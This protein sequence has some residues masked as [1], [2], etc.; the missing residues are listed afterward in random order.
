MEASPVS[1]NLTLRGTAMGSGIHTMIT[2]LEPSPSW[3]RL[4]S[5]VVAVASPDPLLRRRIAS[6][7]HRLGYEVYLATTGPELFDLIFDEDH[8]I[9]KIRPNIVI[10]EQ[11]LPGITG[12]E[13]FEVVKEK[14]W[15]LPYFLIAPLP[16]PRTVWEAQRLRVT[17]IWDRCSKMAKMAKE[18]FELLPPI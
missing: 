3:Y 2:K 10:C 15:A 11:R 1:G 17:A 6:P 7:L 9:A 4:P 13:I 5:T 18:L 8:N 16:D 12:L 14:R